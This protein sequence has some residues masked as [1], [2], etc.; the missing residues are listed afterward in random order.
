[1]STE[2]RI[3]VTDDETVVA[4]HHPAAGDDWIVFC[5]GFL[6]DRT[7][8][9]EGRCEHAVAAGYDAVRFDHR[10]CGDSDGE[11]VDQTLSTRLADLR[12]VLEHFD[13][14]RVVCFGSSFGGAVAL[15]AAVDDPRIEAVVT[16]APVTDPATFDDPRATVEAADELA[17]DD[18][19]AIDRRFFADLDAHD[20]EGVLAALEVP[21]AMFHGAADETVPLADSL[22]AVQ[23]LRGDVLLQVYAGEGHLFSRD[24]EARLRRQTVDWLASLDDA[25]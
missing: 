24:A 3:Q 16:R 15:H 2:H 4:D 7:G 25:A 10:G 5:H 6:S 22:A 8:S 12:A 1:M 18:D 17:F 13:P 23:T 21:V 20:F 14:P 11:F 9:Y 19:R